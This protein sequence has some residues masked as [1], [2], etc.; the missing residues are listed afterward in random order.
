MSSA[1]V[2]GVESGKNLVWV[3]DDWRYVNVWCIIVRV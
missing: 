3:S 2:G 1:M